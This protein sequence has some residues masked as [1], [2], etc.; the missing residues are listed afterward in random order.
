MRYLR[1]LSCLAV[2]LL[3]VACG[4]TEVVV[5]VTRVIERV[6]EVTVEVPVTQVVVVTR[7]VPEIVTVVV[8][9]TAAPASPTPETT[10]T[11]E[12]TAVPTTAP[13]LPPQ[14]TSP[15]TRSYSSA[16]VIAAFQAAGLEVGSTSAIPTDDPGPVP[17]SYV[18]A[19]RFLIPS[20]G[21]DS[22]G[23]VFSFASGGERD[24]VLEYYQN[25]PLAGFT[26]WVTA[27]G[28][29]VLQINN[30]LPRERWLEYVAVFE[31]LQ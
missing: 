26:T 12:P 14:P 28:L 1:R 23:R 8:F 20:L 3:L 27:D 13:T 9:P 21:P 7:I 24:M 4:T 22:G 5:E 29:L 17:N 16:D 11:L 15:P 18:E 19:T 2:V 10:A 31:A 6:A 25:L 30:Q